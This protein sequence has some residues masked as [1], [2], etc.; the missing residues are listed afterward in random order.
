MI[1]AIDTCHSTGSIALV[2]QGVILQQLPLDGGE[3]HG[4]LLFSAIDQLALPLSAIDAFAAGQGPGT[5]TGVRIGLTAIKGLAEAMGKPAFGI[6]NLA[7]LATGPNSIPFYDARRGD[8]YALLPDQGELVLPYSQFLTLIPPGAELV[9]FDSW[10]DLAYTQRP[11]LLAGVI[12]LLA[13]Q[14]FLAGER[15]DPA[16]LDANYVRR[17]DAELQWRDR[18]QS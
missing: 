17:T 5:F 4:H 6:S 8:V 18:V 14:R 10:P 12:G 7:A 15:P 13:E 16:A 9:S 11:R 1:L 3:G 2:H